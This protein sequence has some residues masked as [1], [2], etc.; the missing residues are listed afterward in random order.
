MTLHFVLGYGSNSL[1]PFDYEQQHA[2]PGAWAGLEVQGKANQSTE[3]RVNTGLK[4]S[5]PGPMTEG[6]C[7]KPPTF[8][9]AFLFSRDNNTCYLVLSKAE[10][11]SVSVLVGPVFLKPQYH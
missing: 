7:Q 4:S 8:Q 9:M 10:A 11:T 3:S 5:T 2:L 1:N 6:F